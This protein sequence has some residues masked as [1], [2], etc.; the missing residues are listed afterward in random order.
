MCHHFGP[1]KVFFEHDVAA[2]HVIFEW[3]LNHLVTIPRTSIMVSVDFTF[4]N[5]IVKVDSETI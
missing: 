3:C 1:P 5:Y 2:R 4:P